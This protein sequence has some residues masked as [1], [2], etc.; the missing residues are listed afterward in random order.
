MLTGDNFVML[1]WEE[2]GLLDLEDSK[3]AVYGTLDTWVTW[4]QKFPIA[5]LKNVLFALEKEQQWHRVIHVLAN[6][7]I[8]CTLSKGQ[9][10][11]MGTYQQLIRDL[12]ID[13]RAE[14][15]YRFWVRKIGNDLHSVPWKLCHLMISVYYWNNMLENLVK[16][17]KDLEAFDRKPPEKAIVQKVANAYDMLGLEVEKESIGESVGIGVAQNSGVGQSHEEALESL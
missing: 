14:E 11:T 12:D 3:E 4:E 13:D 15:A 17:F 2:T 1:D 16:L 9:G 10:N 5:P 6:T 8:K 7:V